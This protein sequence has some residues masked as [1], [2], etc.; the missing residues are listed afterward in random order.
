[1]LLFDF[2][3]RGLMIICTVY[4]LVRL[5]QAVARWIDRLSG[6]QPHKRVMRGY[7]T[8]LLASIRVRRFWADL[9]QIAA[10]LVVLGGV[11]YAHKFVM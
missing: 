11:L 5:S 2:Y 10:L 1:M 3:R 8:T 9:L 4:A 7:V 6:D